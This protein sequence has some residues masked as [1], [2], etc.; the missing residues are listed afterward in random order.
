MGGGLNKLHKRRPVKGVHSEKVRIG[1]LRLHRDGYGFVTTQ[2]EAEDVFV[3]ARFIGDAMH[4]D[5]VEVRVVPGRGGKTEGRITRVVEHRV[6]HLM[7]RLERL[8]GAYQVVADD[9]RVRQRIL[10]TNEQKGHARHADNVVVEILTYPG[11]QK[12][13]TGRVIRTLGARGDEATEKVA[14]II[15]HQLKM[16]FTTTATK[17]AR[18]AF[19]LMDEG[20]YAVRSDL[21]A[22]PFVTIDGEY[23][24]DFDDAVA[25][26]RLNDD[27]IR[28]WVSIADVSWF[29][30]PQTALDR[31]AYER[32]TS[33]YFPGDCL[34]MLPE[35]ISNNLCSLRPNE[36]RFTFTAEIV[37]T[38]SGETVNNKFY[39]SVIRSRERMTYTAMKRILVDRD[40]ETCGRFEHL[41]PQF[42]LMEEC[43]R[44][45]RQRRLKNGSIDF[46]LP[47]PEII[48]DM[49]GEVSDIVR[50]ERHV[51]HMI[52]EEFMIR[53]NE[54]VAEFLTARKAGCLYRIHEPP[55]MEKL[56]EF[57][58]LLHNMGYKF[59]VGGHVPPG[60]L[61]RVVDMVRGRP[62]ERLVNH[63]ML[64]SM[65]Q[66]AYSADNKGHYGLASK[67]YC[68]F[69]SP[70]RRYPDLVVHRH[71]AQALAL[72]ETRSRKH[73][74]G[75]KEIAEHCSR[76]E[77]IAM[78]A[79]REMSKLYAAMFMQ[80]HTGESF[81]GI[82]SH[83]TK[84][85]F[86]V[87]LIDFFVEGLVPIGELD[88]DRYHFEEAGLTIR[89]L[90]KK[91]TFRIG[92]KV[93]IEVQEVNIPNREVTFSLDR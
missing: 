27:L 12:P 33:V 21:R 87:E 61:A 59:H 37:I 69:T 40:P 19:G 92:D 80:E 5:I 9:R 28:L 13:M 93:R 66:A 45:L 86:F 25:V 79:E 75:L 30:R 39:R 20:G 76:Q 18:D 82:I 14:V 51:G 6:R 89:G 85:G 73:D 53:A 91:R 1:E 23:A 64:R 78:D 35:D 72:H 83:V 7:G 62:E 81:D 49:Q 63:M 67:C 11:A 57:S 4:T 84:F 34:P 44:R 47:E 65:S 42:E 77:R 56:R 43:F 48:I 3:P 88:D 2:G 24:K 55:P 58:I 41:V 32:S 46:D 38:P 52:I 17:E 74:A 29:V 16:G 31:E 15:R 10:V 68:H 54:A 26:E 8:G 70:I 50:A 36:D 71:L 90:K 22:I 60:A